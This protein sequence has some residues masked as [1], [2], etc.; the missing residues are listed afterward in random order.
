[1]SMTPKSAFYYIPLGVASALL[2]YLVNA[3]A[4]LADQVIA[5]K[6]QIVALS[7]SLQGQQ[8]LAELRDS[9]F[10]EFRRDAK[11]SY[12]NVSELATGLRLLAQAMT[13]QTD[14]ITDL[15]RDMGTAI[16]EINGMKQELV[17]LERVPDEPQTRAVDR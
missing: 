2:G 1:M 10:E 13:T 11:E 7:T 5:Q 3:D 17:R 14:V 4:E 6:E 12:K 9:S 8:R 16:N 15:K